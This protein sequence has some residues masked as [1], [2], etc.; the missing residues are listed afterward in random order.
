MA[1]VGDNI[2]CFKCKQRI[3][4][5]TKKQGRYHTCLPCLREIEKR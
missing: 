3:L 2:V 1:E 5:V 4:I